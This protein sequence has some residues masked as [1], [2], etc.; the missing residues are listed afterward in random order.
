LIETLAGTLFG[1]IIGS[2]LNVC[3][4]RMPRDLSV[5]AP[6]SFCPH[7]E[8][9]IAWYDNIPLVSFLLLG[10]RC[11]HCQA[12]IPLRYLV[13]EL[14]TAASFALVAH[15]YGFTFAGL[16]GCVF[17][18][19][20]IGLVFSD[21]EEFILPDELTVGGAVAGV[22]FA[23]AVPLDSFFMALLVP[24]AW[25]PRPV[26]IAESLLGAIVSSGALWIVGALYQRLRKREGL[27]LGDVKMVAMIGAFLG[28]QGA[29]LTLVIGSVLGSV[30]G[31]LFITIARKD[32]STY[33]LPFGS[34]LGVAALI[35]GVYGPVLLG[36]PRLGP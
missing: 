8:A 25:G 17:S 2:F 32:Y 10:G 1:L 27:G 18:A 36:W 33:E 3:I 21:L 6:R 15:R 26:W 9:P 29:L 22:L 24:Q 31:L 23:L 35:V 30:I 19:L 11:R 12:R 13:V 14:L 5:V 28:L 34:F 4:Y 20:V 7:C 16:K